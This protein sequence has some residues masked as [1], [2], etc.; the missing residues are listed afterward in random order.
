M[1]NAQKGHRMDVLNVGILGTADIAWRAMAPALA[2]DPTVRLVAVASRTEGRAARFAERFGCAAV[3]G[4]ENLLRRDDLAAVYVPL[5]T[6]LH[7]YWVG[8]ALAGGR[9]VLVEKSL[10]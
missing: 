4:Y 1:L 9:H 8:R 7:G 6:G 2:A 10:A 3:T 5:P